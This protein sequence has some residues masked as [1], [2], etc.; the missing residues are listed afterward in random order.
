MAKQLRRA[1]GWAP[2]LL[3]RRAAAAGPRTRVRRSVRASGR[4]G[5][6]LV[7]CEWINAPQSPGWPRPFERS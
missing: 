1:E 6:R 3:D 5:L 4:R 7:V 2:T